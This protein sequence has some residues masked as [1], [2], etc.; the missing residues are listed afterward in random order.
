MSNDVCTCACSL[1]GKG[2]NN[3]EIW[4]RSVTKAD[5]PVGSGT[6][7]SLLDWTFMQQLY[8]KICLL[9]KQVCNVF[10]IAKK[11]ICVVA[12]RNFRPHHH[13][14]PIRDNHRSHVAESMNH[15]S[16]VVKLQTLT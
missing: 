14:R 3:N 13:E 10:Q 1:C 15:T 12:S 4:M 5:A 7:N 6:I 16:L 2:A 9:H 8:G 11:N